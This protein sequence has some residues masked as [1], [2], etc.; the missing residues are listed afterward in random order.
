MNK[1]LA[2]TV[3]EYLK[4][5][6]YCPYCGSDDIVGGEFDSEAVHVYRDVKCLSCQGVFTEVFELT[7]IKFENDEHKTTN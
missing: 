7:N 1:P 3:S 2:I 4:D 6:N 5:P